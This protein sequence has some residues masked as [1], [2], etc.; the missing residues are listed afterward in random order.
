V[1]LAQYEV[2]I[3][4]MIGALLEYSVNGRVTERDGNR[5]GFAAPHNTYPCKGQDRWCVI[6]VFNDEE[7]KALCTC[8]G[9]KDLIS[10]PRFSTVLARKQ[11]E[12]EL[13]KEVAAWT[14]GM[15]AEEVFTL[16]QE[17]GVKA[18]FVETM[19]DMFKDPQLKHRKFWA[20]LTH[21][22]VGKYHA[23]GPPFAFSKTPFKIDRHAPMIGEHNEVVFK[24]FVGLPNEEYDRLVKEGVIS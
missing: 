18:G 10:D 14:S 17:N 6:S 3:Q 20:P 22:E 11:H 24:K 9:R 5:H 23:E 7:W 12:D 19:E 2:G 1:D 13:D 8:M 4:F 15:V 16:L 21:P